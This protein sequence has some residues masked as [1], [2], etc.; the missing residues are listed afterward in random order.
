M[1]EDD[2]TACE[3]DTVV[4]S[5]GDDVTAGVGL[6]LGV[7]VATYEDASVESGSDEDVTAGVGLI[8]MDDVTVREY[9]Y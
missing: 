5:G 8:E 4:E 9:I 3:D 2:V 1:E 6:G 7:L